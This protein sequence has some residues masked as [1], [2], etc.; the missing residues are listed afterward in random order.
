[1]A[2]FRKMRLNISG[3]TGRFYNSND[4]NNRQRTPN[5]ARQKGR[6]TDSYKKSLTSCFGTGESQPKI[7]IVNHK[8]K[9]YTRSQDS[10]L[11]NM[12]FKIKTK[13]EDYEGP[14][15]KRKHSKK[16]EMRVTAFHEG[17]K[18]QSDYL[19]IEMVLLSM[20]LRR[21]YYRVFIWIINK[22]HIILSVGINIQSIS[23]LASRIFGRTGQ[24]KWTSR[25]FRK[26]R[27][28]RWLI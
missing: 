15:G 9:T 25:R 7:D 4:H 2:N 27:S 17:S 24:F 10:N 22:T 21:G 1:M 3:K 23:V 20:R 6:Q 28:R 13:M 16:R 5:M 12:N 18:G 19:F 14:L 26:K 11:L 8:L